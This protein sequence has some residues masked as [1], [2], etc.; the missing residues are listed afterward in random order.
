[1][2]DFKREYARLNAA[3]RQAVETIDGP[4]LVIAGPGTGKTQLLS[5]RVANILAK[6]DAN[7][8]NILCLTFTNKAA[9]NMRERLYQLVGPDSRNV[10]VRTFHSFAAEIMNQYPDYFWQGARLSVAPDAIQLEIIQSILA[11]LPL[12]SPLASTFAGAFTA[13]ND[14]KEALK[15]AKE[16]G[17]MPDQLRANVK[18]NLGYIDKIEPLLANALAPSLS[19]KNLLQLA[20]TINK[21]PIQRLKKG[22]LLLPL[23]VIL[24]ESLTYAIEQD[25]PTNKTKETGRWKQR[26]IQTVN[27][28]RGMF[29]ERQRNAWWLAVADVYEN[30]RE[31]LHQRGYYDYSDMLIEVLEQLSHRP[32]MLADL[33]ERFLYVLID[34]FQDTN[35]AQLRLAKLIADHYAANNRPNLMAVGDDDQSIFAFNGAELNNMLDFRRS[36]PDTKLV[37][38]ADNYRSTQTIL[39]TAQKIIEQAEDRLVKHETNIPKRLTARNAPKGRSQIVHF[40]YPTQSHQYV[41]VVGHIKE[42]WDKGDHD[43]AV[44]ARKHSSLK[45]LASLLL[46]AHVPVRYDQQSN[47]LEHEAIKHICLIASLAVAIAK[48]DRPTVDVGIAELVRHPMWS[49][50]PRTLWK[51]AVSN[52]SAPDWLESLMTHAD[53]KLA[54]IGNW[55]SELARISS[56]QPLSL[57]M[58]QILGLRSSRSLLSPL[59]QYYID[60]R[61]LTSEYLETL[62]AIELLRGLTTEFQ[63]EATLEDFVRFVHLNLS[64]NRVIADESWFSGGERAVQLLTIHKAKGLEFDNVF[65]IDAIE[66][67]WRPRPGGRSS[68]ANLRLQAYGEKYDDYIRLLYV[69][70]SRARRTLIATSYFTDGSGHELLP[71]PLLSALPL[72]TIKHPPEEPMAVLENSLHWPR[73]TSRDEK[74]LLHDRLERFALSPTALIDFL[75]LAESGPTSFLERHLLYLPREQSAV[76]SYGTAIH[77]ALE[78]AQRLINSSKLRLATV[79]DRF[80]S[81]LEEQHL[82]PLEYERFLTRGE[83]LLRRLFRQKILKL[84]RGGLSEQKINDVALESARIRGTID[85]IDRTEGKLLISDYK[86]G[87]ALPSF[88]TKDQTKAVKAWRHQTQLLF[89]CLLVRHSGRFAGTKNISAQMLYLE[90]DK[91]EHMSL[92]LQPSEADLDRLRR[93]IEAVWQHI[94]ELNFPNTS[95]YSSDIEGTRAFESDLLEG[96]I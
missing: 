81:A 54:S 22:A 52:Y 37:V 89:Y 82:A 84:T 1:M 4:V 11:S 58:E 63:A 59:R 24:C 94:M 77:A 41:A 29:K 56:Q 57:V 5:M 8:S 35:A 32:D 85:R 3:Q 80:E 40:S 42:I 38:L 16:S 30:Y 13:L 65:V 9:I 10:V 45:Q 25:T 73:L 75:N 48:G 91:A 93:L 12:D 64:T 76:G 34:E 51:L 26:W 49:L 71:T 43:I 18:A 47:V 61:P 46:K 44:L 28:Q 19:V 92:A 78:T 23:D 83:E 21:L 6:T 7:A 62:S 68:P 88:T 72:K 95:R 69:A 67:M 14:V 53:P 74:A 31:V 50:S 20:A 66:S 33:Q 15:L 55:L 87:K 60:V 2:S 39:D 90:S 96:L 70:A 36:Y 86:T 79:L 17:L 27:G